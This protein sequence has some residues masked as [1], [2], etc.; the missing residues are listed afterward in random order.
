MNILEESQDKILGNDT[1]VEQPKDP[2]DNV[3]EGDEEEE[4]EEEGDG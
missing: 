4:T 3:V 2:E 1:E